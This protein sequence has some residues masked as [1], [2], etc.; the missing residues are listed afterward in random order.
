MLPNGALIDGRTRARL[1]DDA[2]R[3]VLASL[4]PGDCQSCGENLGIEPPA[5]LVDDLDVLAKASLHHPACRAPAWNDSRVI[6]A[7]GD[8][9][10]SWSTVVL[11]LPFQA[12][13]REIRVAGL[14]VNPGLEAVWLERDGGAW[15]PRP[16]KTF[17]S[18]GLMPPAAGFEVG[19]PAPGVAGG[20]TQTSLSAVIDGQ[21]E[22]YETQAEPQIRTLAHE[23]DGFLLIVTHD[24]H[25][26]DLNAETLTRALAS[27]MTV[28]G[29]AALR[30]PVPHDLTPPDPPHLEPT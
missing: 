10:L 12:G 27:P 21:A 7:P 25:P 30:H 14:L 5:L 20:L 8:A 15:H 2:V 29:W 4:W 11:L 17:L 3:E 24:A 26:A 13:S 16:E 18:A 19:R 9:R 23:R 28:T 6:H 1:G 22:T